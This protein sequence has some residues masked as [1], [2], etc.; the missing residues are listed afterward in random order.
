MGNDL[1]EE[2][3]QKRICLGLVEGV[4]LSLECILS[5]LGEILER[6][7]RCFSSLMI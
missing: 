3:G 2:D 6:Y 1:L 4:R 7:N 5:K